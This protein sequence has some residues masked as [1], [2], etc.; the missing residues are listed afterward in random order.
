MA[1]LTPTQSIVDSELDPNCEG[2]TFLQA[3]QMLSREE[4]FM[5]TVSAMN[6]LMIEKGIYTTEEIE[7]YYCQWAIAQQ[8]K[9]KRNRPGWTSKLLSFFR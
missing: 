6:T 8:L 7:R 5:A 1:T 4:R 2:I 3:M 9:P